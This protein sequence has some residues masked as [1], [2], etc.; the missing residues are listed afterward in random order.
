MHH[1]NSDNGYEILSLKRWQPDK[2]LPVIL[3]LVITSFNRSRRVQI[4]LM[5]IMYENE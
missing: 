2:V 4:L 5:V 3:H 1:L